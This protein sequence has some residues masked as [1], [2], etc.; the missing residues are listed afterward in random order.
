ML[1]LPRK[2]KEASRPLSVLV[3]DDVAEITKLIAGWLEEY[4]HSVAHASTG[5]E[6]ISRV[7]DCAYD[8]VIADVV[9]PDGD[10][11]DAILAVNRMR[12]GVRVLAIS[13]GGGKMPAD[14]CLRLAKGV[15]ADAVLKKPFGRSQ[16]LSA[17]EQVMR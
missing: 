7:R 9:M 16:L 17:V 10:G 6:V 4:G 11:W 1:S 15:G 12:P 2:T 5:R 3:A 13:G 14:T 8:L